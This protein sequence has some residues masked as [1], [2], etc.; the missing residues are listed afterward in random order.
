LDFATWRRRRKRRR[1]GAK[2]MLIRRAV[3][4]QHAS[5]RQEVTPRRARVQSDPGDDA[6]E[7]EPE[8]RVIL[9]E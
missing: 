1:R 3:V 4:A 6:S 2:E 5:V 8:T 7:D 9:G